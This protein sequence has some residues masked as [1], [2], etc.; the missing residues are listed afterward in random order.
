V[1]F[2]I[3]PAPTFGSPLLSGEVTSQNLSK[4]VIPANTREMHQ[5]EFESRKELDDDEAE[6]LAKQISARL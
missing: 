3:I 6:F 4:P 1:H 2:H 5:K